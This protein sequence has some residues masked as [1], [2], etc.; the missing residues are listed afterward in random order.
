MRR[1]PVYPLEEQEYIANIHKRSD[2]DQPFGIA[3]VETGELIGMMG[4]HRIDWISRTAITGAWIAD[5]NR[6]KGL[7]SEAKLLL[8]DYAFHSLMLRKISSYVL[9]TNE[10]SRRYNEKCGY[11]LEGKLRK[12]LAVYGDYVDQLCM[13][14]FKEDF[15]PIWAKFKAEQKK[16]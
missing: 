15:D 16:I 8:L 2:T 11:K 9:D 5:G 3:L 10:R 6:E 1:K 7:G 13:A 14:V 4:L 12:Q